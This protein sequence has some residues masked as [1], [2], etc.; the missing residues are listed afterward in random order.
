MCYFLNLIPLDWQRWG[1]AAPSRWPLWIT[2]DK[3]GN[4]YSSLRLE[5]MTDA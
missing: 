2:K 4:L 5:I 3:H 1:D